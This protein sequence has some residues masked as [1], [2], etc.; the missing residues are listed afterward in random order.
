MLLNWEKNGKPEIFGTNYTIYYNIG[1]CKHK[2]L[3][4]FHRSSAMST[5]IK[6]GLK[7]EWPKNHDPYTDLHLW[8]QLNGVTFRPSKHICI[9]IKHGVGKSG[10]HYHTNQLEKY[11]QDDEGLDFLRETIDSES[12]EFYN[13]VHEKIKSN[14]DL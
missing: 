14:F 3:E 9:G 10:G 2:T 1:I 6:P 11:P 12:F 8:K 7:I 13:G 5:M 4:H